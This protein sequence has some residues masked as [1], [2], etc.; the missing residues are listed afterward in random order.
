[1]WMMVGSAEAVLNDREVRQFL[2]EI[3]GEEGLVVL[4]RL[5]EGDA[6][7]E[8]LGAETGVQIRTVRRTLYRLHEYRLASYMRRM[9]E[10]TGVHSYL[11]RLDLD[12]IPSVMEAKKDKILEELRK[13]FA[14]EKNT[15]FFKCKTDGI[16]APF[17][18]AYENDFRCLYC[19]GNVEASDN[20]S[21]LITLEEEIAKLNPRESPK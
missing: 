13:K 11:W 17:E 10:K 12:R 4:H 21:T 3:I 7:D 8:E 15:I 19:G 9:D 20:P 2:L 1:M 18:I 14:F 6:T 16:R 5:L